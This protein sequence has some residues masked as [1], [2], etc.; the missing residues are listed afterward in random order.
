VFPGG[1]G[2]REF[3]ARAETAWRRYA[4]SDDGTLLIVTHGGVI[5]TWCCFFLGIDPAR[6]FVFRPD[7][8]A[9]TLFVR[10]SS[11]ESWNLACFND[12]K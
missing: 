6:R 8:A 11:R 3:E 9:L 5:S 7:Y 2:V 12:R 4:G 10:R 1:C